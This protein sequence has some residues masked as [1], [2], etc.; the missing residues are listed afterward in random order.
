MTESLLMSEPPIEK[1]RWDG[2]S[3]LIQESQEIYE[4]DGVQLEKYVTKILE[5]IKD[6]NKKNK[7]GGRIVLVDEDG[8][9]DDQKEETEVL[10]LKRGPFLSLSQLE[11]MN[12]DKTDTFSRNFMLALRALFANPNPSHANRLVGVDIR[13]NIVDPPTSKNDTVFGVM[14]GPNGEPQI[15]NYVNRCAEHQH[16]E[17]HSH[18]DGNYMK[19][20]FAPFELRCGGRSVTVDSALKDSG[21]VCV[22]VDEKYA[23]ELD[24]KSQPFMLQQMQGDLS[25]PCYICDCVFMGK[26]FEVVVARSLEVWPKNVPVNIAGTQI[27]HHFV[28]MDDPRRGI[29]SA[30]RYTP[31]K[32]QRKGKRKIDASADVAVAET[33]AHA[34][35]VVFGL[36][37]VF[38]SQA[39]AEA[40][41]L[42]DTVKKGRTKKESKEDEGSQEVSVV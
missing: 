27:L 11:K 13:G 34:P 4:I 30:H 36:P 10:K 9:A 41:G 15:E 1:I 18:E 35:R 21:A 19:A 14:L 8:G 6:A 23:T 16:S 39:K 12:A 22:F 7:K 33:G 31:N 37:I 29:F 40:E 28:T 20:G 17:A 3:G 26:K 42:V 38:E 25:V 32:E 24:L 2:W 5:K